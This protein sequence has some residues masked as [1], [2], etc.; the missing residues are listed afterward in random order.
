MKRLTLLMLKKQ[1]NRQTNNHKLSEIWLSILTNQTKLKPSNQ[2]KTKVITTANLNWTPEGVWVGY[3]FGYL[4]TVWKQGKPVDTTNTILPRE[5]S[6]V[7]YDAKK[8]LRNLTATNQELSHV[9]FKFPVGTGQYTLFHSISY[10]A[11]DGGLGDFPCS[12]DG[13][14]TSEGD[15]K[16][17][18]EVAATENQGKRFV[19]ASVTSW[20]ANKNKHYNSSPSFGNPDIEWKMW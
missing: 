4:G 3:H 8:A 11:C 13:D 5:S 10:L 20:L 14:L 19:L 6:T 1:T 17:I 18:G 15:L 2:I 7:H 16:R 9:T 12:G